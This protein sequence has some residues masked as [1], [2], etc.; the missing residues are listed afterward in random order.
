MTKVFGGN[1]NYVRQNILS[2]L[3]FC[4]NAGAFLYV[5]CNKYEKIS[6]YPTKNK[7]DIFLPDKIFQN[8]IGLALVVILQLTYQS[9][10][11]MTPY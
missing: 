3:K 4:L 11:V 9:S 5:M 8:S 1:E 7:S 10:D 2:K 6:K